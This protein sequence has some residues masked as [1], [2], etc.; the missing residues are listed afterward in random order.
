MGTGMQGDPLMEAR[1]TELDVIS[2]LIWI[3][4]LWKGFEL[5]P[6]HLKLD[7]YWICKFIILISI[8]NKQLGCL[9]SSSVL[10]YIFIY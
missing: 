4:E 9:S 10:F 3:K 5:N 8:R 1:L 7:L 2:F 6:M